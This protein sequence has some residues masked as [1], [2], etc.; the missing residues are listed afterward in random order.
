MISLL[1]INFDRQNWRLYFD[2]VSLLSFCTDF[3]LGDA[4]EPRDKSEWTQMFEKR[5]LGGQIRTHLMFASNSKISRILCGSRKSIDPKRTQVFIY[6]L[7]YL[8]VYTR[9]E[10]TIPVS[11]CWCLYGYCYYYNA[12]HSLFVAQCCAHATY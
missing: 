12:F 6:T 10:F 4:T 1:P 8:T 11:W 7:S 3:W 9:G 2:F 5:F